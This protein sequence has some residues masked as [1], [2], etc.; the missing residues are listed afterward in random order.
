MAN[1]EGTDFSLC[2]MFFCCTVGNEAATFVSHKAVLDQGSGPD[3]PAVMDKEVGPAY[4]EPCFMGYKSVRD[5]EAR[6]ESLRILR[7]HNKPELV[8]LDA[9]LFLKLDSSFRLVTHP[10]RSCGSFLMLLHLP[11]STRRLPR[12]V[13]TSLRRQHG[14]RRDIR[15]SVET[16][17]LHVVNVARFVEELPL[18]YISTTKETLKISD[19]L[20]SR[21]NHDGYTARAAETAPTT[22]RARR[23]IGAGRDTVGQSIE[24]AATNVTNPVSTDHITPGQHCMPNDSTH[25]AHDTASKFWTSA[26]VANSSETGVEFMD[27]S[28]TNNKEWNKAQSRK[29]SHKTLSDSASSSGTVRKQ[30]NVCEGLTVIFAATKPDQKL[31]TL[32]SLRLSNALEKLCPECILQIR[33]NER[34]NVVAVDVRNGQTTRTLLRYPEHCGVS[35]RAYQSLEGPASIAIGWPHSQSTSSWGDRCRKAD[36]QRVTFANFRA[37]RTSTTPSDGIQ[38]PSNPATVDT[39]G[40]VPLN[41]GTATFVRPGVFNSVLDLSFATPQLSARWQP[42]HDSWGSDHIPIIISSPSSTSAAHRNCRVVN[43]DQYRLHLQDLLSEGNV[44]ITTAIS[45]ALNDAMRLVQVPVFRPNLDLLYL[46]LKARRRQAQNR[47]LRTRRMEDIQRYRRI[48]AAFCRHTNRLQRKQWRQKCESLGAPGGARQAWRMA[49]AL[50]SEVVPRLQISAF[51]ISQNIT[52]AR[53]ADLL[54]DQFSRPITPPSDLQ[55]SSSV[56]PLHQLPGIDSDFTLKELQHGLRKSTRR[57]STPGPDGITYQALNNIDPIM[58]PKLLEELNSV[59]STAALPAQRHL[60]RQTLTRSTSNLLQRFDRRPDSRLGKVYAEFK[61]SVGTLND[62]PPPPPPHTTVSL[63]RSEQIPQL[64]GKKFVSD[65][66]SRIL[67][68]E[69]E[70][71]TDA[72]ITPELAIIKSGR[73]NF[74]ISSTIAELKALELALDTL[75]DLQSPERAVLLSDSRAALQSLSNLEDAPPIARIIAFKWLPSHCGIDGNKRADRI[76]AE[77]HELTNSTLH[78]QKVN[79]ARL[80]IARETQKRHPDL[81]VAGGTPPPPVPTKLG[82]PEAALLHRLRTRS[83]FTASWLYRIKRVNS[84]HCQTCQVPEDIEHLLCDCPI[85]DVQRSRLHL[86]LRQIG[87]ARQSLSHLLFPPGTRGIATKTFALLLTFLEDTGLADH[88]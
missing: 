41:D 82:R 87:P 78:V 60:A 49:R 84:P 54:A 15:L 71:S 38:A 40:L 70:S 8:D 9:A 51:A 80:L 66:F 83:A 11:P 29:R 72:V 65:V 79:E 26:S 3:K 63:N 69:H 2:N 10:T 58:L 21:R 88:L 52:L 81:G 27:E 39:L 43:W 74:H 33:P 31:A 14:T 5:D 17:L 44:D 67:A 28:N 61:E 35:V 59:W 47:S 4:K 34:H 45:Q 1:D 19:C 76:A 68:E 7:H 6:L 36:I 75:H 50:T 32:S 20:K 18:R 37:A 85:F 62:D 46:T 77:A 22:A 25:D 13:Y 53:T 42:Q 55:I 56:T 30:P 16:D 12:Y 24:S 48:D 23:T 64:C 73:L 57:K 86:E